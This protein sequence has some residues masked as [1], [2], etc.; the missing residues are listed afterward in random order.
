MNLAGVVLMTLLS[1]LISAENKTTVLVR[2]DKV[3]ITRGDVD[4]AAA[5]RQI[6]PED[7]AEKEDE[8]INELIDQQLV[9]AFLAK[10]KIEAPS[11]QLQFQIGRA[12]EVI[13]KQ[14]EDPTQ[15]LAKIGYTQERLKRELG[16][17]L[18]WQAY[19]RKTVTS[20]EI[21]NYYNAHKSELDGTQVRA[22]QILLK[23]PKDIGRNNSGTLA[24]TDELKA[25]LVHIRDLINSG[26]ISFEDAAKKYSE[27]PSAE[28]GGDVGL[29]GWNGKM[30]Q[31]VVGVAFDLK[32]D[33]MS[34]PIQTP[35]GF[36]LIKLTERHPGELSPE[37]VRPQILDRL[38][39]ELWQKVVSEEKKLT[40]ID[41][42]SKK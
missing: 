6:K 35:Y 3:A 28:N 18:A 26:S 14:G 23:Y 33:E 32:V 22:S 19:V 40:K 42:K 16:L 30:P 29:F 9:R 5:Q 13:R 37:D 12:Q 7:R 1:A 8:L 17:P 11:D 24:D 38:A 21:K 36:H 10:K 25:R 34:R 27:A 39:E 20:E 4:F 2:V 15:F 31:N 41:W